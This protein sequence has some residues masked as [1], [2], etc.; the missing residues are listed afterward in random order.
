MIIYYSG[1]ATR[2]NPEIV[3]GDEAN[4]MLTYIDYC[5]ANKPSR[6]FRDIIKK[7]RQKA[8]KQKKRKS[9]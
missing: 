2:A 9:G 7:R 4:I 3:L 8:K 1:D 5:K 6:R